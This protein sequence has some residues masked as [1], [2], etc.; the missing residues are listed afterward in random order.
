MGPACRASEPAMVRQAVFDGHHDALTASSSDALARGHGA[1]AFDLPL[2]RAGGVV[3]SIWAIFTPSPEGDRGCGPRI[4]N[5]GYEVPYAPGVPRR[6]AFRH[7]L[8]CAGHLLTLERDGRLRVARTV[9]DL[10]AAAATGL[11]AAI[12]HLEGAEA[13]DPALASLAT[14]YALGLR[15]LGVCWSRP[16]AFGHGVP[17]RFPSTPDVGPGLTEAGCELVRRCNDLGILV[18]V[19]HLNAA[20]FTDVARVSTAPVVA[21]HSGAHAIAPASRNLTDSQLDVIR[22]SGGLVGIPFIA[23][24][25]R[26][27]GRLSPDAGVSAIVDHVVHVADRIGVDHVAFGSDFDGGTAL[28]GL[29]DV[30]K[31][32]VLLDALRER[33]FD[34]G[35]VA[36]I[37][38]GN[39]RRVLEA[40]WRDEPAAASR[41]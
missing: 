15:S 30:G 36:A 19:S 17:L 32:P 18:D 22:A 1:G 21:T 16:N 3:A 25:V 38:W 35:E 5:G 9:L 8:E 13:I 26:R 29:G 40:T 14:W 39:W 4:T 33:G 27:D 6:D 10:D 37:A 31:T 24:F 7:A 12:L 34:D 41:S 11:H 20:G 28:A 23:E 2:A